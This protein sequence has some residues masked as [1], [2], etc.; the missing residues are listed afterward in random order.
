MDTDKLDLMNFK[1][2]LM[3]EVERRDIDVWLD[4]V[5]TLE[6]LTS[7]GADGVVSATG[8]LPLC[9]PVPGIRYTHETMDTYNGDVKLDHKVVMVDDGLVGCEAGPFLQKTDHEVAAVKLL[10]RLAN[11][12]FGMYRETLT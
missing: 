2:L 4:I 1:N 6:N 3:R 8:S 10:D 9:P 12:S 11:E 5:I 7:F